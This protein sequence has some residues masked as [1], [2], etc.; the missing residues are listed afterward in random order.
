[1]A[2]A[3]QEAQLRRCKIILLASYS[4]QA[5]GFYQKNGYELAWQLSDFPPGHQY[6]YLVKRLA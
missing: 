1:M 6:H 3:E 5:P 4:F 2:A